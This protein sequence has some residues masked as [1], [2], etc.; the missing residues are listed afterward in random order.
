MPA[1]EAFRL[2]IK[3]LVLLLFCGLLS[4]LHSVRAETPAHESCISTVEQSEADSGKSPQSGKDSFERSYAV[5][6]CLRKAAAQAGTEWLNTG[7]LLKKSS[8]EAENGHR[9]VAFELV[10]KA[11]FQAETALQQADYEARAWQ[12]RVIRTKET[13]R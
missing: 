4:S 8:E 1:S 7:Q 13:A 3:T 5:A 6:E 11:R 12:R 9:D 2:N 10:N